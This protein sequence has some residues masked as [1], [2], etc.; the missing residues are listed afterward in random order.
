[1][2]YDLVLH[3]GV[4]SVG[5]LRS[6]VVVHSLLGSIL[7]AEVLAQR[8]QSPQAGQTRNLLKICNLMQVLKFI[9]SLPDSMNIQT[10]KKPLGAS[11]ESL[12]S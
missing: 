7:V 3:P 11:S 9:K 6:V 1:M 12:G 5:S 10:Y 2:S 4:V 8:S